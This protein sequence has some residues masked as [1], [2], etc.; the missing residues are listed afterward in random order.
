MAIIPVLDRIGVGIDTAR[1]GHRVWFLRPDQQPA[2]KPLTVLESRA[3]YQALQQRLEQLHRQ[4][5]QARF[6]IRID[7]A[8]QYAANLEH[9]LR[10]LDLPMTLSIGE[11]KRN[12]DYQK[13]HFPKRTTDDT[14]SQA[15]AR[16]AV[17]EQPTATLATTPA[18]I[19]LREVAGRL[20]AKVKQSTQAINRLHN[21]LARVFPELAT[22]T[23]D[24]SAGWVLHL[25]H[26]Y[27]TAPRIAQA[28][29]AS[30]QQ[31]PHLAPELAEQVQLAAQQSVA[32]LAG[33][34]AE[35][36]V[37]DLVAHVRHTQQAEQGMRQLLNEAFAALPASPHEQVI[38]VP[39]IGTA[40]AAV[41]VAK[42]ADIDRFA[43]PDK[44]VGYFGVFPEENSSGVDKHGHPLP[45]GTLRMS[46]KGNDLVRSYLWN[47]ARAAIR[48][49]PA[50]AALYRRLKDKGTRGDV[51]L[52]HCMRKLLHLAY[53]VW[54]SNR[55]F[56]PNHF[57]R[58]QPRDNTLSASPRSD[59][60]LS[61]S[62]RSESQSDS[63]LS[64]IPRSD[65]A[66][67]QSPRSE[68][69]SDSQLSATPQTDNTLSATPPDTPLSDSPLSATETAGV[70]ATKQTAVGHKRD[71]PAEE[72]VTTA[73]VTLTPPPPP[74]KRAPRPQVDFTFLRQQVTMTQVLE[75][76]GLL[77]DL[78]G[79]GLQRRG[80]C[81]IHGQAG[82]AQRTFS[83]HLGK[84][85]F[86]CFHADCRAQG[87]VLDLWAAVQ[88]LSLYDAALH[89]AETFQVPRN[90]EEE[91]VTGTR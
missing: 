35:T 14:E 29:L 70:D 33:D 28:R 72:V 75:H 67:S 63:A 61:Q 22:L 77:S 27:P 74:V 85:L 90:R 10:G 9:F 32:A 57:V 42:I 36:L 12:K 80:R 54:K 1:Y 26:K 76:L 39:G 60:A 84:N 21:L 56:D 4:H 18:M 17:I 46:A 58:E 68:S 52:G 15:M 2:A 45:L 65:S 62:P 89:L 7:A 81:P 8:G 53:A 24:L 41:L 66:L 20:Q 82:D 79:R 16:F 5:P 64:V 50:I 31:I 59:S 37:R 13:A 55:P 73:P 69:Q 44:F 83:A 30:L 91:P 11:P 48:H 40:T 78:R 34:V 51:A 19:A 6:H 87:N 23:D 71:L 38:T 43:S 3:G 47:A 25:L 49:N 88:H 86:Q